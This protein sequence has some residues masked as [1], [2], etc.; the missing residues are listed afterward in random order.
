MKKW[1][2]LLLIL[3]IASVITG[4]FAMLIC[5]YN[6]VKNAKFLCAA[7]ANDDLT[8]VRKLVE[9]NPK[10]VHSLPTMEPYAL[11]EIRFSSNPYYPL[12]CAC[13]WDRFEIIQYLIENGADCNQ[14]SK[15]GITEFTPLML[16]VM[17][18]DNKEVILYLLD[19]GADPNIKI[20]RKTTALSLAVEYQKE[21]FIPILKERMTGTED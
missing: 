3:L 10:I 14:T 8:Q 19:H 20:R 9:G 21:E 13:A 11:R 5:K 2:P 15:G 6:T 7:I 1:Q 12:Q 16:A 18:T 4:S 17:H